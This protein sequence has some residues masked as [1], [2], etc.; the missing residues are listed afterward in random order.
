[1]GHD[2]RVNRSNVSMCLFLDF[3]QLYRR[4]FLY[5]H[6]HFYCIG[7]ID[8]W[9]ESDGWMELERW[10]DG[11]LVWYNVMSAQKSNEN[12][13]FPSTIEWWKDYDEETWWWWWTIGKKY[14][15][16]QH[17]QHSLIGPWMTSIFSQWKLKI[18]FCSN[19]IIVMMMMMIQKIWHNKQ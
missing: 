12:F 10:L 15:T 5:N 2:T 9:I 8:E 18:E 1:M 13:T 4:L 7:W 6:H 3:L 11:W 19:I 16:H 17:Q 14:L